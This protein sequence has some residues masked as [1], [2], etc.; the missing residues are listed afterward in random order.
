MK[1]AQKR[2]RKPIS[3]YSTTRQKG[4]ILPPSSPDVNNSNET[5]PKMLSEFALANHSPLYGPNVGLNQQISQHFHQPPPITSQTPES[6]WNVPHMRNPYFTGREDLLVHLHEQLQNRQVSDFARPLAICGLSGIGKTQLAIEYAYY[7]QQE[8]HYVLWAL[9]DSKESLIA[10]Y[11]EIAYLL[12]LSERNDMDQQQIVET[13]KVWLQAHSEWLL[14]FDNAD[15]STLLPAFL[16]AN[17]GGHILITTQ[18]ATL[19]RLAKC[20]KVETFTEEQGI[21]FLLQRTGLLDTN[22]SLEQINQQQRDYAQ[23]LTR[24]LGGLPLALDHAG[25]YI[26]A[27]QC[28]INDYLTLYYTQRE[29]LFQQRGSYNWDYPESVNT[30]FQL[31]FSKVGQLSESAL[32]VIMICAF[33]Y[34]EDIPEEIFH[35]VV[36]EDNLK[37]NNIIA[38]LSRYSLI[39]RNKE[40]KTLSIHRLVQLVALDMMKKS[41][42][43]QKMVD[44][45]LQTITNFWDSRSENWKRYEH[46][47]I[48]CAELLMREKV[49]SSDVAAFLLRSGRY[50]S[51][52]GRY[53]QASPLLS[54]A[55]ELLKAYVEEDHP[56]ILDAYLDLAGIYLEKRDYLATGNILYDLMDKFDL[57]NKIDNNIE[58]NNI[59]M[60]RII[61]QFAALQ[62]SMGEYDLA[63]NIII[64]ILDKNKQL[65][66]KDPM[67]LLTNWNQLAIIYHTQAKYDDAERILNCIIDLCMK[68]RTVANTSSFF[69]SLLNL[70]TIYTDQGHYN[71]AKNLLESLIYI[72]M[73]AYGKYHSH[74]S[75]AL[76]LLMNLFVEQYGIKE[77]VKLALKEIKEKF[78]SMFLLFQKDHF[79]FSTWESEALM[80]WYP[81]NEDLN[82]H[83][84]AIFEPSVNSDYEKALEEYF[85]PNVRKIIS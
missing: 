61:T 13:V 79:V 18:A 52:R 24:E 70:T 65:L 66:S 45:A 62:A 55:C 60:L 14:V 38:I 2:R 54:Q 25:A 76:N 85:G 59:S 12:K 15:E 1:K 84:I 9:A 31:T 17:F 57:V 71:D 28:N 42:M 23:D 82:D 58:I 10:S 77:G 81:P 16:P 35:R 3:Q 75:K 68:N 63:E 20:I 48:T 40:R 49:I 26:E 53:F 27:T 50:L 6:A 74:T 69:L 29:A 30:T 8:Y 67:I 39:R 73:N 34:A 11:T 32:S 7:Y 33:L 21:F 4:P 83:V 36:E 47:A 37:W 41:G 22:S 5:I 19:G 80:S 44:Q 51:T 46:H 78:G 64:R 72:G 56:K 43:F